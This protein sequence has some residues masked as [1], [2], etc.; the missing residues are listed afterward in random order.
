MLEKGQH[1]QLTSIVVVRT[2]SHSWL[3][4]CLMRTGW[5]RKKKKKIKE[6]HSAPLNL[7]FNHKDCSIENGE[8]F[9]FTLKHFQLFVCI[10][11]SFDDVLFKILTL[12]DEWDSKLSYKLDLQGNPSPYSALDVLTQTVPVSTGGETFI[13]TFPSDYWLLCVAD[14]DWM[15]FQGTGLS[16]L[17]SSDHT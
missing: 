7:F 3:V 10:F 11:A 13:H 6:K 5:R 12:W 1:T 16:G 14:W 17:Y 8:R 4:I 9:Y 2:C 15:I